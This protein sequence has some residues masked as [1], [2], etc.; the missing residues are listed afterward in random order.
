M[1][2]EPEQLE[3][4]EEK[5]TS[6]KKSEEELIRQRLANLIFKKSTRKKGFG[7]SKRKEDNT[8]DT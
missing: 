6:L 7:R 1:D 3:E 2:E 8:A 4:E 5:G